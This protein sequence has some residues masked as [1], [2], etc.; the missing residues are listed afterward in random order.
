MFNLEER[1]E[2]TM[3]KITIQNGITTIEVKEDGLD[4]SNPQSEQR[5]ITRDEWDKLN[6]QNSNG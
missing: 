3:T 2:R 4:E 6:N 1:R 5:S